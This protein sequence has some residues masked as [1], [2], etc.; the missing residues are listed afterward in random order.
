MLNS[1]LSKCIHQNK[2]LFDCLFYDVVLE[3]L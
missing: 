2:Y 3:I 1:H